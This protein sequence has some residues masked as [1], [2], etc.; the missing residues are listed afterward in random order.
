MPRF[1][2][3]QSGNPGGRPKGCGNAAKVARSYT[4]MAVFA[5][6][7]VACDTQATPGLQRRAALDLLRIGYG[8]GV[9]QA[10]SKVGPTQSPARW[11]ELGRLLRAMLAEHEREEGTG[12]L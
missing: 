5:L 1:Q 10:A 11:P 12:S 8:L 4:Y 9:V 3:G 6:A 7:R 2:P